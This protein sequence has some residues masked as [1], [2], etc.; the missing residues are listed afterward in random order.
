LRIDEPAPGEAEELGFPP[1]SA[2]VTD[3]TPFGP[4]DRRGV[5]VGMRV[6][7]IDGTPVQSAREA[8]ARIRRVP[9]GQI[10]SIELENPG[11]VR[12]IANMRVP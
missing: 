5:F 8:T 4:A 10:V 11:G 2:I 12:R 7:S 9:S 6:A 1:G 3:V